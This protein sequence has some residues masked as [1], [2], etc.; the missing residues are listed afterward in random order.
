MDATVGTHN[1]FDVRIPKL[2]C[3]TPAVLPSLSLSAAGRL[4]PDAAAAAGAENS[5]SDG[6]VLGRVGEAVQ[7]DRDVTGGQRCGEALRPHCGMR[8]H[9]DGHRNWPGRL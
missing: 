6:A 7:R 2:R 8:A 5:D 3:H 1:N 4:R 9:H